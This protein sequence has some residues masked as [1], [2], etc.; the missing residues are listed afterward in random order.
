VKFLEGP[1]KKLF[2]LMSFVVWL[3]FPA[4]FFF[5][6]KVGIQP[7]SAAR[8]FPVRVSF[9]SLFDDEMVFL[10]FEE[11][12]LDLRPFEFFF[13]LLAF[14]FFFPLLSDRF[15]RVFFFFLVPWRAGLT[16]IERKSKMG[17]FLQPQ[18]THA[19]SPVRTAPFY[20]FFF[21]LGT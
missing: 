12:L 13:F 10:P 15:E 18:Q 4:Q 11:S 5:F 2:P 14:F 1:W 9:F 16:N 19:L 3:R 17:E 8:V 21:L 20:G 6:E 7:F